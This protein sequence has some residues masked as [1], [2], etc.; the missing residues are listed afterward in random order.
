MYFCKKIYNEMLNWIANKLTQGFNFVGE[1]ISQGY[2]YVRNSLNSFLNRNQAVQQNEDSSTVNKSNIS[3][4]LTRR[5]YGTTFTWKL[6]ISKTTGNY[7]KDVEEILNEKKV[8]K[9]LEDYCLLYTSP[10][11]RDRQKSRMPS[12]A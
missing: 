8:I 2:N 5:T 12:S 6:K 4:V 1:K 11:P 3:E 10:S 9:F 7:V